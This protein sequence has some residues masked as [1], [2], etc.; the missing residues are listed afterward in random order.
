MDQGNS[1]VVFS[2]WKY[3][4]Y[5]SLIEIKG[6]NVYVTCTLCPGK[7]TL[8]TSAS[9]NSNLMKQH[10]QHIVSS[11]EG[12]GATLLKQATLDFSGQQQV[13]KAELNTLIARYVVENMLPLSTVESESFRA[14]LAKI[15]IRG[16][17]R[18][19]AP[20]R[21]TFAKFIDS[22]YEKINIELKKSFEEIEYISTTADIW[23]AHNKIYMGVTAHWINPNNM[24]REKA[25]LACRQFKGHHTHDAIAVELDNIH[26]TYGITHKIT[27]TVTDN[28]SNFV[29][30]F[31]R[32]QPLEESDSEDDEDEVTF[33]DINDALHRCASH[34]LNLISC[35][36][37][38]KWLLSK[39]ATKA[40][41][42]SATAKCTALWNKTS[43]STLATE[44]VDELVSKKLLVPCTT[45]WNSFYDA[46]ARICEISKVDLNTIS[47]KLGLTAI[48]EREH[49]FLKEYCT[50][51][52][53]LTVALDI[54]QGED[55]C[56]HGTLLP[57]METLMLKTEAIKTR[58]ADVLGNEEAILAAV[59]LPKFKLRWLRSQE[60]KDKA[61]GS[62]LAECRKIVLKEPQ[63]PPLQ[64]KTRWQT[65]LNLQHKNFNSLCGFSLI[66]KISLRYNAATPS[67]APV[68]RLFS[69]GKL[70]FS[71][72]GTDCQTK[73]SKKLLLLRYNHWFSR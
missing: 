39:P 15:P 2:N 7:K 72:R 41:Y 68:E 37:V 32:Y 18:G 56:F 16:G 48:T 36:D 67:S 54:L 6:K 62:L 70:V 73:D 47:S 21:N 19:V 29:K 24:E 33:T 40:V 14:I 38:D 28:G 46:L 25:A 31:K 9:S 49:Q 1:K 42:R 34:T 45:R 65:I 71:P 51:M 50:V 30:A 60:L 43:R 55:N 63:T 11:S 8:S 69:L 61:K 35:T 58:F 64:Q 27:A 26:S 53:P 59:T 52:K 44:T 10:N 23:T 17:G 4:H 13:T 20:C 5:F 22:E 3:Q 66:K 12:D 57:T